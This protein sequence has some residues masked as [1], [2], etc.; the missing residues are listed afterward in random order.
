M[1]PNMKIKVPA[2]E[3]II[4]IPA[5]ASIQPDE[6][7]HLSW[8][9]SLVS[10]NAVMLEIGSFRGTSAIAMSL[11]AKQAGKT[12][13]MYCVD[14][15]MRGIKL[16]GIEYHGV[17]TFKDYID[18]LIKFDL[19]FSTVPIM[20]LSSEANVIW[21]L[22]IDLLF[23]DADHKY[24]PV[25]YDAKQWGKFVKRG[26]YIAFH[27]YG[28]RFTGVAQTIKELFIND[29]WDDTHQVNSIWSARKK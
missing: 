28:G 16:C 2:Y 4:K 23:I 12:F 26:G 1:D 19:L 10:D 21:K 5:K 14:M 9:G 25:N 6:I 18:N 7:Q 13:T 22:P 11:G 8:L 27:D 3:E 24:A 29:Q 17:Q 20:A 15:W